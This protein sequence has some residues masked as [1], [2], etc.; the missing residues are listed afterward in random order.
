MKLCK[1]GNYK[2][3]CRKCSKKNYCKHSLY[4][5]SC[6][7]C[8]IYSPMELTFRRILLNSRNTDKKLGL[9]DEDNFITKKWLYNHLTEYGMTCFHCDIQMTAGYRC[10]TLLTIERLDVKVGHNKDNCMFCC[11]KCN[12]KKLHNKPKHNLTIDTNID[13]EIKVFDNINVK[14]ILLD[15]KY[16]I[17]NN[18]NA[19]VKI[20]ILK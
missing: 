1:H 15:G 11:L 8:S 16:H 2:C 7:E 13:T 12:L 20:E 17:T 18:S 10:D 5:W 6:K 4:K 9:Y 14:S 19:V 3:N